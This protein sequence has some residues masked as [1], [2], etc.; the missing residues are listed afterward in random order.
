MNINSDFCRSLFPLLEP[1]TDILLAF[2]GGV[3]SAV[4]AYLGKMAGLRVHAVCMR[5]L[6][7]SE[8]D[9]SIVQNTADAL[10]IPL[11]F[12]D[13]REE[14]RNR[15]MYR[16]WEIFNS[17]KTP[18]PCIYCNPLIKFGVLSDF[19][20]S[21]GYKAVIT[22]HYARN[23]RT[24]DNQ[25]SL[26][27]G[28]Y[29]QKDQS[30]FLYPLSAEQLAFSYFPLGTF[31]KPE[32]RTIAAELHLPNAERKESQDVCFAPTDGTPV[33]EFLR[34]FFQKD[35]RHG[36]F[37]HAETGK[38][39]G[40]H[41]GIHC[42]T[43]GQRKGTGIALGAP[44]YI[45]KIDPVHAAVYISS[46]EKTLF[47]NTFSIETCSGCGAKNVAEPF[48]ANVQ[49]RY[50]SPAVPAMVYPQPDGTCLV[51]TDTPVR[52]VTPGQAAVFYDTADEYV[53]GGGIIMNPIERG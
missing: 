10:D 40:Q 3:D 28:I 14:F 47:R 20:V 19:A 42:Y 32:I 33:A 31:T 5:L 13:F 48:R 51:K 30:Y 29:R 35:F 9:L 36:C 49:I 21:K 38:I 52:A 45:S 7:T 16:C 17:G 43:I 2:S 12:A 27:R 46:D 11:E 39:L 41:R 23:I 25:C 34:G 1:Q 53:L 24:A 44:A 50:R 8:Q 26:A 22:G 6:N 4:A 15:V 37:I 18:N